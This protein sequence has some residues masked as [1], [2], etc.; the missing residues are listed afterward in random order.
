MSVK[1]SAL[2]GI[3]LV[4]ILIGQ[5]AFAQKTTPANTAPVFIPMPKDIQ[6]D[7]Q[8]MSFRSVVGENGQMVN[9][10]GSVDKVICWITSNSPEQKKEIP[11]ASTAITG[12]M[13][14]T[15]DFGKLKV[16]P[17]NNINSA[18]LSIAIR[19]D[20]LQSFRAFLQKSEA[21]TGAA[22]ASNPHSAPPSHRAVPHAL[23]G[24]LSPSDLIIKDANGQKFSG[25]I[26]V[27][28]DAAECR[29]VSFEMH[30][31]R[32]IHSSE[33]KFTK[34]PGA[35][36]IFYPGISLRFV[37]HAC[38][39]SKGSSLSLNPDIS[40]EPEP[41]GS[42]G[43]DHNQLVTAGAL[44][45]TGKESLV[46]PFA[47]ST[48]DFDA[49]PNDALIFQITESGYQYTSGTGSVRLPGGQV[50]NFPLAPQRAGSAAEKTDSHAAGQQTPASTTQPSPVAS[51][52][53]AAKK[54][55][56]ASA[57]KSSAT[58]TLTTPKDKASYAI[59]MNVGKK[60]GK[61]LKEHSVDIDQA[62][63]LR[64]MKDG[65]AGDKTLLTDE[66][67]TA[68][69]VELQKEVAQAEADANKKKGAAFLAQNK[70]KDGVVTL[71]SGLQ[72]KILQ[73]GTG[74]KPTPKDI[75]VCNYRGTLVDGKE[76]D[77]SAKHGK[78]ATFPVGQVIKG[79]TE[80]LQLMPVGSKW[81]LFVPPDL[82]YGERSMGPDITPFSTLIF[83][84]E[85]VSIR[86]PEKPAENPTTPPAAKPAANPADKPAD[87]PAAKPAD[88]PSTPDASTEK[89]KP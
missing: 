16:T 54:P 77:S 56:T 18:G 58:L 24:L 87:A 26:K 67:A 82:A 83:E 6:C 73:Q 10:D 69:I 30:D 78:P 13:L 88:K 27:T 41:G 46:A 9:T 4:G 79:W 48:I 68:A 62:V 42:M 5:P 12:G 40:I 25:I 81:Q 43:L 36:D 11:L 86:P 44:I 89:P 17:V 28:A 37:G 55:A 34:S 47:D 3:L 8:G 14:P 70:T 51:P 19:R 60:M 22:A 49:S 63:L 20:K 50:Y 52:T 7:V 29:S 31:V 85:L 74:P 1:M 61:D 38:I 33:E 2:F 15:K 59:G 64:G 80:A 72:Y 84:V 45:V 75:V 23:P 35:F 39:P 57:A 76:F 65:L 71:P 21:G 53:P 66:E 32:I